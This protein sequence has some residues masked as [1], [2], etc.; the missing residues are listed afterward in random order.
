MVSKAADRSRRQRHYTN[1][2][3]EMI[4]NVQKSSFSGMMFRVSKLVLIILV[5]VRIKTE[6]HF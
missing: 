5:I 2:I 4:V 3:D 1:G 6:E